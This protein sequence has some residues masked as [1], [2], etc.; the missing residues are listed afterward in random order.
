MVTRIG[1]NA[2]NILVGSSRAD[3]IY[4]YD[5]QST[6]APTIAA[7]AITS[8][9]N[10][11]LYLTIPPG[12]PNRL[13]VVEKGG[14]VKIHNAAT[15]QTLAT[16]FLDVSNQVA[17]S[18]E[19]GLLGLAFA[20]DY[21][22]S[23]KFYVYLSN[24]AGDTEIREYQTLASDPSRADAASMRRITT[25]DYPSTTTNHRGGWIGFGPDGYL[26]AATGDGAVR[27][28]AQS[29]NQL[30]KILRLDVNADAFPNDAGRNYAAPADNPASIAGISGSA[31]GTGIFAA[32]LRNP[33]R[34]SFDRQTGELYIG[35]VGEG[36]FE[37]I[38]LG[39]AGANYGWSLT[40]GPFNS[41]SFPNFTNPIH[42]YGRA[43]GQA[44][45]G[46][47]VYRGPEE[48]FQGQYFFSDFSTSRIWTL[49]PAN[50][51]RLLADYT[52]Q[53]AVAGGPINSV[54]SLG[55]DASGN[56]YIVDIGGKIFRLDLT[57]GGAADP[58]ADAGDDLRG[59]GGNDTIDGGGGR[60][61]LRGENGSDRLEGGAGADRLLGGNGFDFAVYSDSPQRVVVDLSRITQ[62]GG[63]AAGDRFSSIEGVFGSAF[64][65]IIRGSNGN[66]AVNAGA[67]ND[68]VSGRA[69]NDRLSGNAG[70][71]WINGGPGRDTMSGG[72]GVD[73]VSYAGF[74]AGVTV[75]LGRSLQRG[76]GA[77][78]DVLSG[79]ENIAGSSHNDVLIGD[80]LANLLS[81][82]AGHDRLSGR[83]GNDVLRGG[84]GNDQM[85][86]QAGAD[87]LEGG[88]G[89]DLFRWRSVAESRADSADLVLDFRRS[90]GDRFDLAQIDAN[91][92]RGGSQT[93]AFVG[94]DAFTAAGQVR[95]A[96]QGAETH[97]L[98][99][100]D[101]DLEAEGMIRLN[102]VFTIR[103]GD[104]ML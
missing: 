33:W 69:G 49:Q 14:L 104:F 48:A 46:G 88:A 8:G 41:S 54:P 16:P 24:T 80:A 12:D 58:A 50:G 10:S 92:T 79:F 42:S 103:A 70:D 13:F 27:A 90:A 72:S 40:E 35:D 67:G 62:S 100:V 18:G 38:N 66:D 73:T 89:R 7:T 20:P 29:L 74:A 19:Q 43:S 25:I 31:A 99:N 60:D 75:D 68:S 28:N 61:T 87:I 82:G 44:V 15:G 6:S 9:L 65:D 63:E 97:V 86:G 85:R 101:G 51:S 30:G 3:T 95:Y 36:T 59:G 57:S 84:A 39:R 53:T 11:P 81:G 55:E 23:R 76:P 64:N 52:D 93:F 71:D 47:Y 34:A 32:G 91:T 4:G 5:P 45:T 83:T 102:G 78:G 77:L 26:Y 37:E 2:E 1:N 56:L 21:A 17:T 22:T 94:T 96:V 98:L